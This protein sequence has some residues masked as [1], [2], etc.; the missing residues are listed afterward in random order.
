MGNM[1]ER[2]TEKIGFVMDLDEEKNPPKEIR[3]AFKYTFLAPA[4]GS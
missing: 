2:V 3:R 1:G 4:T